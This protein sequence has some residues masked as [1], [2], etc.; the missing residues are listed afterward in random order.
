[1]AEQA[2]QAIAGYRVVRLLG[3]GGMGEVYLVQHPRLPRRDA[4]K[5]LNAAMS[6]NQDFKA[7]FLREADLLAPLSHPNIVTLHD[8]GEFEGRLWLTMEYI[9]GTDAA[10]LLASRGPFTLDLAADVIGGAG[11]ALDYAW[12]KQQITHRDV[13]PANIL[14]AIDGTVAETVKLADFGIAKAAG[15]ATSLTSTGVTVGT[16]SYIAPE[17]IEGRDLDNRADIYSLGCTA[18]ELLTGT[19]PYAGNSI[20]ALMSAHLYRPVPPVTERAPRL[21]GY[22]DAVFARVLAKDPADRYSSCAEFTAALRNPTPIAR[23]PQPN[24]TDAV[25]PTVQRSAT[26]LG[27][28]STDRPTGPRAPAPS[29][30]RGKVIAL[31]AVILALA[32][33]A[34]VIGVALARGGSTTASGPAASPAP[35]AGAPSPAPPTPAPVPVTTTPAPTPVTTTAITTEPAAPSFASF[36]GSWHAHEEGLT[37]ASNGTGRETYSDT[38]SCPDAP[39]SGCGVTGTVD[40]ALA[41]VSGNTATGTITASSNTKN[42][43]GGAVSITLVGGGQGLT[44]TVAGGDQGFPFCNSNDTAQAG[45]YYCGA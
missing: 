25:R 11:G 18:F 1:M 7:R 35:L 15:E 19:L 17:A 13:K 38:S 44:L 37:I 31:V 12:R 6:G 21:P 24:T 34:A 39:M 28:P 27:A 36:A 43:V 29:D 14:V 8:R 33:I 41:S 30:S 22:L 5:L 40:F 20:P 32:A 42:P 16:M 26:P 2:Y 3:V 45:T 9:D 10:R 4:L 23:A